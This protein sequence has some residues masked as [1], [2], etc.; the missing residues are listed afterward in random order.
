MSTLDNTPSFTGEYAPNTV[1]PLPEGSVGYQRSR[2]LLD[3]MRAL[4]DVSDMTGL[5]FDEVY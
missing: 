3:S 2:E 5:P 4:R 1:S